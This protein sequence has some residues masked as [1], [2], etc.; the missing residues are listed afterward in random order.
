MLCYVFCTTI[1]KNLYEVGKTKVIPILRVE[2]LRRAN[3][4]LLF[5]QA[6]QRGEEIE[7]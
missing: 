4:L 7:P 3:G 6:I 1:K 2:K 5:T